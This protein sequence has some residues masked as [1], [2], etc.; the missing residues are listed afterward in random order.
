MTVG[1]LL[2]RIDFD[3]N[4][5]PILAKKLGQLMQT[6]KN[7]QARV[8]DQLAESHAAE[9]LEHALTEN[10]CSAILSRLVSRSPDDVIDSITSTI[11]CDQGFS[12]ELAKRIPFGVIQQRVYSAATTGS[13]A[14]VKC[15][16]DEILRA[17]QQSPQ[18]AVLPDT[19]FKWFQQL[20]THYKVSPEQYLHLTSIIFQKNP[21]RE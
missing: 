6:D 18:D 17:A 16:L 3:K 2:K 13:P 5:A 4:S 15:V 10:M 14:E 1:E 9:I 20:I 19:F 12:T 8:F 21:P 11:N 7:V